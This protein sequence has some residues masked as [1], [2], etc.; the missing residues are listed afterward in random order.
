MIHEG[1]KKR[2]LDAFLSKKFRNVTNP[3][4]IDHLLKSTQDKARKLKLEKYVLEDKVAILQ[5]QINDLEYEKKARREKLSMTA[6]EYEEQIESLRNQRARLE[7]EKDKEIE[8]LKDILVD[9]KLSASKIREE[10]TNLEQEYKDRVYNYNKILR[11]Y[12]REIDEE[13]IIR[14]KLLKECDREFEKNKEEV[15]ELLVEK[16]EL[17]NKV[18]EVCHLLDELNDDLINKQRQLESMSTKYTRAKDDLQSKLERIQEKKEEWNNKEKD[19]NR[20]RKQLSDQSYANNDTEQRINKKQLE[21]DTKQKD[22]IA[23]K[24][25]VQNLADENNSLRNTIN[26]LQQKNQKLNDTLYGTKCMTSPRN[27][28]GEMTTPGKSKLLT[29]KEPLARSTEKLIEVLRINSPIRKGVAAECLSPSTPHLEA[30]NNHTIAGS[31]IA[32]V[33]FLIMV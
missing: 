10:Q 17:E 21:I 13:E 2:S 23:W 7:E 28:E 31:I 29:D 19:T 12:E 14:G 16:M 33:F 30:N 26:E 5:Q 18:K 4:Y 25:I 32:A 27:I 20:I 1:T 15:N 9:L 24:Q 22:A 11:D 8:E 6:K 3:Q